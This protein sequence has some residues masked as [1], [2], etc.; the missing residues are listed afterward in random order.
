MVSVKLFGSTHMTSVFDKVK[1]EN[2]GWRDCRS[3][4]TNGKEPA[5]AL[6]NLGKRPRGSSGTNGLNDAS[7]VETISREKVSWWRQFSEHSC[8]SAR[9]YWKPYIYIIL[10]TLWCSKWKL[11][12]TR[13]HQWQSLFRRSILPLGPI[14]FG[15]VYICPYMPYPVI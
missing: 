7:N 8:K 11:I 2:H 10:L 12:T 4:R 6:G 15:G 1:R 5:T 14:S 3:Y 9:G 13:S